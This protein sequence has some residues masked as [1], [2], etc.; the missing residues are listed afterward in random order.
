M[1]VAAHAQT[2]FKQITGPRSRP[3]SAS[4]ETTLTLP[5]ATRCW[6]RRS[7]DSTAKYW[8]T[9]QVDRSRLRAEVETLAIDMARCFS[10]PTPE[11]EEFNQ[12]PSA[13]F[14]TPDGITI[15]VAGNKDDATVDI[16]LNRTAD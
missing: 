3:N 11:I 8:C 1:R 2:D 13:M 7:S 9:W 6:I 10:V 5:G 15:Y 4:Y 12:E 16:A 14:D